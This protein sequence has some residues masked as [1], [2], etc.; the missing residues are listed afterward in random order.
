MREKNTS[1]K[2]VIIY[3]ATPDSQ[4][5]TEIKA[6]LDILKD[7]QSIQGILNKDGFKTEILGLRFPLMEK[8]QYLIDFKPD[9]VFNLCEGLGENSSS[10]IH[11]ASVLELFNIPFTGSGP[12][13]LALCHNKALTKAILNT[14]HIPTPQ[15][16]VIKPGDKISKNGL[17]FPLIV[18]PIHEDGSFGIEDDSVVSNMQELKNKTIMIHKVFHQP[19]I[20][21]EYIDGREFNVSILGNNSFDFVQMRE[22]EFSPSSDVKILSFKSKWKQSSL[23][24]QATL[25]TSVKQLSKSIE[26]KILCLAQECFR[27]FNMRDYARIDFRFGKSEVP[28]VIDINPNPCISDGSGMVL[29]AKQNK[30]NYA[31]LIRKIAHLGLARSSALQSSRRHS[32]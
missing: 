18:K 13:A 10:E 17:G 22:I 1:R 11:V 28:Y 2:I 3:D 12:L 30:I 6:A 8:I 7:V 32:F 21:E 24:Y 14:H 19:A 27:I 20:I 5:D 16:L 9:L 25:S 26:N 4:Q 31:N 29:A 23:D 15:Y